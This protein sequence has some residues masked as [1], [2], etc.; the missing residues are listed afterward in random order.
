MTPETSRFRGAVIGGFDRRDVTQYIEQ[1]AKKH[2]DEVE[3]LTKRLE[4]AEQEKAELAAAL[5]GLRTESGDLADQ[6]ARIRTSLEESTQ[7]LTK[8]RGELKTTQ[9]QLAVAKK[10]L[11]GLQAKVAQLEPLAQRYEAL[12]DRVATV[13]LDAHHK[14]QATV[15]EAQARADGL[16]ED[17]RRWVAELSAGYTA[18]RD[19]LRACAQ[20]TAEASR[21]LEEKEAAYQDLLRRAGIQGE[22]PSEGEDR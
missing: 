10:E 2:R 11:G 15:D 22:A 14:A 3:A 4:E 20:H 1:T 19:E 5:A 16:R 21:A 17:A 8:L 13:E 6:E 18:L 9:T 7:S 12:K